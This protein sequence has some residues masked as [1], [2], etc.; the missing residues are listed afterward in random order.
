MIAKKEFYYA[1]S[2]LSMLLTYPVSIYFITKYLSQFE[3]GFFYAMFALAQIQILADL[4]FNST[5]GYYISSYWHKLLI[6]NNEVVGCEDS[7]LGIKSLL[8]SA[9]RWMVILIPLSI[10]LIGIIGYQILSRVSHEA[11]I[12]WG[13]PWILVS[14]SIGINL[15]SSSLRVIAEN[16]YHLKESQKAS[17]FSLLLSNMCLCTA[18]YFGMGLY[19]LSL[20]L[21]VQGLIINFYLFGKLQPI[22]NLIYLKEQNLIKLP[23][24]FIKQQ[25][26]AGIG[27]IA[28]YIMYQ[29]FVPILILNVGA[30]EAGQFG[31]LMQ[32]YFFCHSLSM[33]WLANEQP[34]FGKY[35]A[36][37]SSSM[38]LNSLNTLIKKS[39]ITSFIIIFMIISVIYLAKEY[40]PNY[41]DRI[42]GM[43]VCSVMLF[44]V[45]LK[46]PQAIYASAIRYGKKEPFLIPVF[47][48]SIVVMLVNYF[49]SKY[50]LFY[51][52]VAYLIFNGIILTYITSKISIKII[53]NHFK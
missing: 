49:C 37:S 41:G 48:V 1:I 2:K 27:G 23:V 5:L 31:L 22:I 4:G 43:L 36:S 30:V 50:S 14:I 52:A 17:I 38:L 10:I 34:Y 7:K 16:S 21:I 3:Q 42:S 25:I 28:S 9:I 53:G 47:A 40:L 32:I 12:D 26:L 35:W 13:V 46:Q 6:L 11:K 19:S 33:I 44:V 20:L 24:Q 51:L 29:S 45:I 8:S 18:L 39:F 15:L